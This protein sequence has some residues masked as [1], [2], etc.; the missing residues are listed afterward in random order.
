MFLVHRWSL[1]NVNKPLLLLCKIRAN[2]QT[3]L[4]LNSHPYVYVYSLHTYGTTFWKTTCTEN[5]GRFWPD[6][7]P[8]L[9]KRHTEFVFSVQI[10]H[11]HKF[12]LQVCIVFWT[13]SIRT[14]IFFCTDFCIRQMFHSSFLRDRLLVLYLWRL[15]YET[16]F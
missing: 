12:C 1:T 3:R 13:E 16:D 9:V 10:R 15:F 6:S 2:W 4:Q 7:V 5:L 14:R 8:I 11:R